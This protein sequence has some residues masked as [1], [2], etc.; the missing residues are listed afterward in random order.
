M[1][2]KRRAFDNVPEA[3]LQAYAGLPCVLVWDVEKGA[4]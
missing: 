4:V 3:T 2:S 1:P